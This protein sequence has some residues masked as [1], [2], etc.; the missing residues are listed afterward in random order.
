MRSKLSLPV[1]QG[2]IPW[3]PGP[4]PHSRG[5][6][7]R[8]GVG[9]RG[10]SPALRGPRA[11]RSSP[12]VTPFVP[13]TR[14]HRSDPLL[15][16]GA[17]IEDSALRPPGLVVPSSPGLLGAPKCS[18]VLRPGEGARVTRLLSGLWKRT[19]SSPHPQRS[20]ATPQHLHPGD[21]PRVP[22]VRPKAGRREGCTAAA[23]GAP[24]RPHEVSVPAG[25]RPRSQLPPEVPEGS[26]QGNRGC[27]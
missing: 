24:V 5:L 11:L 3:A 14:G 7:E 12:R 21:R 25:P 1:F 16:Q 9:V 4:G 2:V 19:Q 10:V 20:P 13:S 15:S 17:S 22:V 6:G 8:S 26:R 18:M 27:K 23:V